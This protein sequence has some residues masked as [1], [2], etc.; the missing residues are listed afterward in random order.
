MNLGFY[1][2]GEKGLRVLEGFLQEFGPEP[3]AFVCIGIDKHVDNDFSS[4]IQDA[5]NRHHVRHA[6]RSQFDEDALPCKVDYRFAIGW[7]WMI[8]N[9]DGLIVLHD[10]PLPRY[11]GFAPLVNML[12]ND[13]NEIG[14]TA[15]LASEEYDTGPIIAQKRMPVSYPITIAQAISDISV[16]YVEI[17]LEIGSSLIAGNALRPTPQIE[18]DAT[19]SL[20]RDEADYRIDWSQD[21]AEVRRFIDAV[22]SPYAG[23][24]TYAGQRPVRILKAAVL[25]DVVVE[26]RSEHLGK[27][28]FRRNGRPV[29]ICGSGL[30]SIECARLDDDTPV[31][32]LPFRTRFTRDPQR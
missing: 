20:W 30:L 31:A 29:V 2:M 4:E 11:R 7:R 13:E 16:L 24:L 25:D 3:V 9:T 19:Y 28:I 26:S 18:S 6:L 23:A 1:L 15:L 12:I 10:S 14:V 27:I 32:E 8:A 17:A 22:G 21:A 5:C